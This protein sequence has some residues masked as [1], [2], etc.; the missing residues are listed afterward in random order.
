MDSSVFGVWWKLSVLPFHCCIRFIVCCFLKWNHLLLHLFLLDLHFSCY[1]YN[2]LS[3][4][5]ANALTWFAFVCMSGLLLLDQSLPP[6]VEV[7]NFEPSRW[8]C[9]FPHNLYVSTEFCRIQYWPVI[10]FIFSFKSKFRKLSHSHKTAN[11]VKSTDYLSSQQQN[12]TA[13]QEIFQLLMR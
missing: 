4:V 6:A 5:S 8:I 10:T 13:T 12:S 9:P 2:V 1:Y 11:L 3:S 7:G